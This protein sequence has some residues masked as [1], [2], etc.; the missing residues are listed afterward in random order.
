MFVELIATIVAGAAAAGL[1]LLIN[2]ALGGKMPRWLA[3][4]MAGVAM[5]AATIS[6]EYGWFERT[7][8]T[9]PDGLVVAHTVE[10]K[11]VYRPWT[12]LV[13][14]VE[15]FVAIDTF[16][17]QTHTSQPG[18]KLAE[19]YFFGR[20]STV[21]KLPVLTDCVDT[22]RAALIDGVTFEVDGVVEGA[23]WVDVP[24]DDPLV[25]TICGAG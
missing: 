17:I 1:V 4:V 14:Y 13:P 24:D 10:N 18:M 20:W 23:E 15:R 9:L 12:Y 8:E 6:N 3:P 7:K 11:A 5:L 19:A 25:S 22:R 21:N 2:R 16:S